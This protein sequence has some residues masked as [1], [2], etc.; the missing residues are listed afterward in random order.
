M[1]FV[2]TS[3][4]LNKN[5]N[6]DVYKYF[7]YDDANPTLHKIIKYLDDPHTATPPIEHQRQEGATIRYP[8]QEELTSEI[9][10]YWMTQLEI[11][12]TCEKW[13]INRLLRLIDLI[14][15]KTRKAN[16]KANPKAPKMSKADFYK[17]QAAVNAA[18]RAKLHSKG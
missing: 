13:N 11:P 1:T 15:D 12:F 14:N 18:R 16:E 9:I 8:D 10:Y 5:V 17:K 3:S 4:G 6:P 7:R 2:S